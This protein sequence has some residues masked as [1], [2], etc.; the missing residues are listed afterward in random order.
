M[1]YLEIGFNDFLLRPLEASYTEQI[2]IDSVSSTG[3]ISGSQIK[4][5][6]IVSIN[7]NL[8][9]DLE[10]NS[11]VVLDND[12]KRVELGKLSDGTIGMIIRDTQGNILMHIS[13]DVN[14]IM[15]ASGN[16]EMDFI[17]ERIIVYDEGKTPKVLLGK[18][19]GG[20]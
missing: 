19:T 13:S 12:I 11:F 9:L 1:N 6:Q 8:S 17:E 7:K 16:L 5:D 3:Q 14:K 18:Q 2:G 15:S 10:N 20:F 4:G